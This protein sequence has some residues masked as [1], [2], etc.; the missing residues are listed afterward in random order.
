MPK[1]CHDVGLYAGADIHWTD[2]CRIQR[3]NIGRHDIADVDIIASLP[4][5][6]VNDRS[7]V[8]QE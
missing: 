8:A 5:I 6:A 7:F 3:R 1:N 2:E 4:T